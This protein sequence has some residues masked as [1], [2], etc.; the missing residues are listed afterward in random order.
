MSQKESCNNKAVNIR[1]VNLTG[2]YGST[3]I[4]DKINLEVRRSE[5]L[6][7]LGPSGAGKTSTLKMIAGFAPPSYSGKIY[8][9]EEDI[10]Y[11]SPHVRKVAMVWQGYALWPHMNVYEHVKFPLEKE[12]Y[13][14]REI[15]EQVNIF[16]RMVKLGGF[17]KKKINKLS[18]GQ[19]QR[20]ALARALASN[21]PVLLL[22]EPLSAVDKKTREETQLE[23][24]KM[25]QK[26]GKTVIYVTHDQSEALAISDRIAVMNDESKIGKIVQIGSPQELYEKPRSKFVAKFIGKSNIIEG[27]IISVNSREFTICTPKGLKIRC[28][29]KIKLPQ[30]D[31]F[32]F[33]IRPERIFFLNK[34]EN[35]T[36]FCEGI[37]EDIVYFGESTRYAVRVCDSEILTLVQQNCG[38]RLKPNRGERVR[39]GWKPEDVWIV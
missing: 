35:V 8:I 7:L 17:E 38:E 25:Q 33:V 15:K 37:I 26:L 24:R 21:Y 28:S 14:A 30:A 18:G 34:S 16:L 19:Q 27:K 9:D 31:K 13:S 29:Q 11:K 36:D 20:V 22:D 10:T 6:T 12:K 4:V 2:Y 39:I 23:I 3:K 32:A 1:L 5:F